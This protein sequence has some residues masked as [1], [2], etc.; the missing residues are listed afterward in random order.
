MKS[1]LIGCLVACFAGPMFLVPALSG[2]VAPSD[3]LP[4]FV[5][6]LEIEIAELDVMVTDRRGEP[7]LGLT[8]EDFELRVDGEPTPV[9][10]VATETL[11]EPPRASV[12]GAEASGAEPPAPAPTRPDPLHLLVVVDNRHATPGERKRVL[13]DL[14]G[15]FSEGLGGP[16]YRA[17]V[18]VYDGGVT[19]RQPFTEDG[20][21]I[22]A[23][24]RELGGQAVTGY[25]AGLDRRGVLREIERASADQDFEAQSALA[26]VESY[27][28]QQATEL[29]RTFGAL[30]QVVDS[31]SGLPGR[32]IL[33]YVASGLE[34]Q[35]GR[36]LLAAW[37]NKFGDVDLPR[38]VSS[39]DLSRGRVN[40]SHELR[41]LARDANA[42]RVA[43]YAVGTSGA[44]AGGGI[45]SE[46]G[47]F[48]LGA[49]GS[50]G[51]GRTWDAGVQAAFEAS[52]GRGLGLL[53]TATGGEALLRSG[54]YDLIATRVK[55]HAS[56]SYSLTFR[57]P[58][59][60]PGA[61]HR[62]EIHVPGRDV[63]LQYRRELVVATPQER[64]VETTLAALLWKAGENP[65]GVEVALGPSQPYEEGRGVLVPIMVQIPF[66]ELALVPREQYHSGRVSIFVA[67]SDE[68][69]RIS[70]VETIEAPIRIPN[71]QMV[72]ALRGV[73]GYRVGLAMRPG[74]HRIAV[75]VRDEIGDRV[76]TLRIDHRV[77]PPSDS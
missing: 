60:E 21:E 35:P 24:L 33:L 67:S 19:L 38:G 77:V 8:R 7:V 65:M 6:R 5:D 32:K 16:G 46:E 57:L 30:R 2:Q 22:G 45:S 12:V 62:I 61:S 73:A 69:G 48:D 34:T 39:L 14:A 59:S 26:T 56:H 10:S 58:E 51:G 41:E 53:A 63:R 4:V 37:R 49:M 36:S 25:G 68:E 29:Q 9:E 15:S 54:N 3:P 40:L 66:A 70:P 11:E 27:I 42:S 55:R 44:G 72:E 71:A 1:H 76:S 74:P 64:A 17:A 28:D 47:G 31:L 52:Q 43:F 23:A 50:E 13:N 20:G 75:G 18:V